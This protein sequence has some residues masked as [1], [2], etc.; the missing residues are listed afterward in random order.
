[1]CAWCPQRSEGASG[2]LEL[3]FTSSCGPLYGSWEPVAAMLQEQQL[4]LT[5]EPLL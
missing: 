1:M 5:A 4:V 3:E 2:Q